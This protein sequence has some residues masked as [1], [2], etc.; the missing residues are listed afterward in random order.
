M[1]DSQQSSPQARLPLTLEPPA[2][3]V[4]DALRAALEDL[5]PDSM[6]PREAL[7]ALYRLKEL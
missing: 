5:D 3:D 7:E 1:R 2:E 6:T 4:P